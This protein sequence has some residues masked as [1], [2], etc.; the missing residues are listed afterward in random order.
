MH[1]RT[2]SLAL[3]AAVFFAACATPGTNTDA[4]KRKAVKVTQTERG[5][6][7]T[8]DERILFDSGKSNL[9]SEGQAYIDRVSQILKEKSK[10]NVSV[11][12]YTD[13]TGTAESNARLSDAR[14]QAV[15]TA[16][17][18]SGVDGKRV[19]AKGFG[20]SKPVADNATP[21]GR[22]MN[23]RTEIVLLGETIENVGGESLGDRLS[24]GF[25]NFLKDPA[26]TLKNVFN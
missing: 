21:E 19:T 2:I 23:R 13:N 1:I 8:S 14:A 18:K 7:I 17:V 20:F 3:S 26:G 4:S 16:L 10:A 11:E 24:E 6:V 12:G 22:Q 9:K 5:V 15:K 25:A